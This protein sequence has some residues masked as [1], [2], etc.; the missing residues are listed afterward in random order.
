MATS[1]APTTTRTR[2]RG[3]NITLWVLQVL[4]AVFFLAAASA[5][6]LLGQQAAV[7]MFTDIGAGQWLRYLV[8]IL[9]LAG[10]VG[11][12]VPR[13]SG[14]AAIG[15]AALMVGAFIT[16]LFVL[17]SPALTVTP[18][19]LCVLFVLVAWGRWPQTRAL[20]GK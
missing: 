19:V 16:Q 18:A 20:A 9:E 11:L 4:L 12:L 17:H 8:G 15:L 13:L 5:P 7:D 3:L 6:K 14:L 10:A 1:D 2:G